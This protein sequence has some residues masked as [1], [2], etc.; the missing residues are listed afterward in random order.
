M[1]LQKT[2]TAA[3]IKANLNSSKN[4]IGHSYA[5]WLAPSNWFILGSIR[6]DS[7]GSRL[8]QPASGDHNRSKKWRIMPGIWQR[9][10]GKYPKGIPQQSPGLRGGCEGR[11]TLG[12]G[13]RCLTTPTGLWPVALLLPWAATLSAFR[14][15][16]DRTHDPRVARSSQP[17][18]LLR[19]CGIP[20][21]FG[22]VADLCEEP[23]F[24]EIGHRACLGC[25]PA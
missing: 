3:K 13:C 21:G 10:A 16:I 18:A 23:D 19:L 9:L 14:V 1:T 25:L 5:I 2:S 17:W 4:R 24:L 22:T 20:L 12:K 7:A 15:V 11:A 8:W 6:R